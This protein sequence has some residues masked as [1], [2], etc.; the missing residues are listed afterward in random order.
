MERHDKGGYLVR[1]VTYSDPFS[2]NKNQEIWDIMTTYPHLCAS[3][4]LAQ[5]L[6]KK[7]DRCHFKYLRAYEHVFKRLF[8][9]WLNDSMTDLNIYLCISE[10]I[11]KLTERQRRVFKNNISSVIESIRLL[12]LLGIE[13]K[14]CTIERCTQEQKLLLE[15]YSKVKENKCFDGIQKVK[16]FTRDE[17]E[18]ALRWGVI[19]EIARALE[20]EDRLHE[21]NKIKELKQEFGQ[22]LDEEIKSLQQK[23]TKSGLVKDYGGEKL[24]RYSHY[25]D[26]LN[27][28]LLKDNKIVIHGVHNITQIMYLF[29]KRLEKVMNIEVIFSFNF[30]SFL[31]IL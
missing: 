2:L 3:D 7:Y 24:A 13:G 5:G 30:I 25:K 29:C 20:K 10:E 31:N 8:K 21:N 9:K 15:I 1:I 26:L 27:M 18:E 4:T 28:D 11:S 22:L 6:A 17:L 12:L 16:Y 14:D 23:K 19:E